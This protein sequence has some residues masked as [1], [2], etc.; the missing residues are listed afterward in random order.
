LLLSCLRFDSL[1]IYFHCFFSE[2]NIF[3]L[4]CVSV[5]FY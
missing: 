2:L 3:I 4:L 1:F 5:F